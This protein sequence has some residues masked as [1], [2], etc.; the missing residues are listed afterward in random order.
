MTNNPMSS[1]NNITIV[2]GELLSSNDATEYHNIVGGL[3]Y[4]T[5]TSPNISF[6]VNR[7]CTYLHASRDTH[8]LV[9]KRILRYVR[10]TMSYTGLHLRP[11]PT[12]V[13]LAYS[14]ADWS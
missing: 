1:T 8:W 13:L 14:D 6:S 4:L 9:V 2:D 5:I 12:V 3:Q 11:N 10:Y 7:V